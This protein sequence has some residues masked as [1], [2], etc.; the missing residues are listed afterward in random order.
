M[1]R[2]RTPIEAAEASTLA[3]ALVVGAFGRHCLIE[4]DDGR[5]LVAHPRG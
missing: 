2:R 4:T 5:R 1:N 3:S